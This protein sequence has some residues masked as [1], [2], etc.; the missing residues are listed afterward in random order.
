MQE[1]LNSP[2]TKIQI[3]YVKRY[4]QRPISQR[5]WEKAIREYNPDIVHV[6]ISAL[7]DTTMPGIIKNNVPIKFDTLHSS[8]YRYKGK[9]KRI[10]SDAFRNQGVI[11]VCVTEA[12]VEEAR[13]WYGI[14]AYEVVRN[15]VDIENI[16]KKCCT[17][18]EARKQFEIEMDKFV[19]IGVGRLNPIKKYDLLIN[20]FA[21][22][23]KM[24]PNSVLLKRCG[25]FS[26][27]VNAFGPGLSIA[28]YGPIVVNNTARIGKNCRI[29]E[30]VTIGATGRN[31][32]AAII[33]NN[34]FLATGAK[35]IGDV[36]LG[37]DIAVGA[38]AVVVKSF[39][40]NGITVGGYLLKKLVIITP[41]IFWRR[42]C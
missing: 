26:I 9:I 38:N 12:Q 23:K 18:E 1:T 2:R 8:P 30:G 15:G 6:H 17:K 25:G 4:F 28:H 31:G 16:K 21:E 7:L 20:S 41:M 34:C 27:P 24:K 35:I 29:H 10:I 39:L 40:E 3:P 19:V 32:Q 33:G 11:P 36:Q 42:I 14:K 5:T 22:V 37:N 13:E